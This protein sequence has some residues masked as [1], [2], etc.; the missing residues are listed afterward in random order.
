MN[1]L[2]EE[3]TSLCIFS[4]FAILLILKH[5]MEGQCIILRSEMLEFWFC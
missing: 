2:L 4:L 5:L 1:H 3:I